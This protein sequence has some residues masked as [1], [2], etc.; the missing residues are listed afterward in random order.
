MPTFY[1]V[2]S[3]RCRIGGVRGRTLHLVDFATRAK[4][5]LRA[6]R[7][8]DIAAAKAAR[9]RDADIRMRVRRDSVT[10]VLLDGEAWAVD[11]LSGE[12]V[13]FEQVQEWWTKRYGGRE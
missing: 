4:F 2:T 12:P 1:E 11:V 10:Y 7:D 13:T 6:E 9:G 3:R 5:T 8:E